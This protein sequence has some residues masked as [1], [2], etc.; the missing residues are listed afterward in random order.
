VKPETGSSSEAILGFAD[1]L[2]DSRRAQPEQRR[3]FENWVAFQVSSRA[4][5]LPVSHVLEILRLEKLTDVPN[6]PQPVAGVM[7]LR[8]HVLPV[9]DTHALLDLPRL[10]P[11]AASRVLVCLIEERPIGLIVDDVSGLERLQVELVQA[12]A[13][14]DPLAHLSRGA[15]P[16][17]DYDALLL[18]DP[19]RLFSRPASAF[20]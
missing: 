12:A 1:R 9:L 13:Q 17:D 16:R 11:T 15:F 18:L 3:T 10:A 8:G 2:R 5:G 20:N 14:D 6:A 7:N 19:A 4:L